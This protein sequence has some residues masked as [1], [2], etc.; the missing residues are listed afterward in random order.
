[1]L[2][3]I[4]IW[5]ILMFV[6]HLHHMIKHNW[7]SPWLFEFQF[8]ISQVV[9]KCLQR[10]FWQVYFKLYAC[11]VTGVATS[12][13]FKNP[14]SSFGL[15]YDWLSAVTGKDT[16]VC[17]TQWRFQLNLQPLYLPATVSK[18]FAGDQAVR[19]RIF[20]TFTWCIWL[21]VKQG[22]PPTKER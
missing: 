19:L 7:Y 4:T 12:D 13:E 3:L 2:F 18:T 6:L 16:D 14:A 17:V 20:Q 10:K 1:M 11:T 22:P 5:I 8:K 21:R 9:L 15:W